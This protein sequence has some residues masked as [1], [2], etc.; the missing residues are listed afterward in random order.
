MATHH[1]KRGENEPVEAYEHRCDGLRRR[2]TARVGR[3]KVAGEG[4]PPG[5]KRL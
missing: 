1:G 4:G 2:A 5:L 3:R